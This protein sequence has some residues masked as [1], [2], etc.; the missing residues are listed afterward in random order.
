MDARSRG[1]LL[2]LFLLAPLA[3]AQTPSHAVVLRDERLAVAWN[4]EASGSGR[5]RLLRTHAPWRFVAPALTV[6]ADA[7]LRR[8]GA[9]LWAVSRA[10]GTLTEVDLATWSVARTIDLGAGSL[11]LDVAFSGAGRAY[12]SREGATTLLRIDL[13]S[14][15]TAE[16]VDL[17]L[18][19]DADGVPD[20]GTLAVHE[21]RLF[22][23]VLRLSAQGPAPST[24]PPMLA[25]VDL[26]TEALVDVDPVTPG[27]QAIALAGRPPRMR[28][29]VVP[30]TR[31][32]Y[33]S[34][35]GG[36]FDEGGIE[37]VDLDALRSTGLV[38]READGQVGADL[39]AFVLV[40]PTRGFLVFSTDFALSS[41]PSTFTLSGEVQPVPDLYVVL[42]WFAPALAHAPRARAVFFPEAGWVPGGLQVFDAATGARLTGA[43][44]PLG[45]PP[46]DLELVPWPVREPRE[47]PAGP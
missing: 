17:G 15:A 36:F 39:G 12:V 9:S 8:D 27:V 23:Q 19:A 26:A 34:A 43:P 3:R 42:N 22:V 13:A 47:Q 2:A 30:A 25:V 32:L 41:H 28:M 21:G 24:P 33:L 18:F 35:T 31:R 10:A 6:G 7:R 20:L 5:V 37:E 14:G 4:D 40:S 44:I 45:G 46:T 29:Q 11:P 16:V 38:V 1:S